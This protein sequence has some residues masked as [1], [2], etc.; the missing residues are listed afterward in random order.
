MVHAGRQIVG[1]RATPERPARTDFN[2]VR[3]HSALDNQTPNEFARHRAATL[4]P[5]QLAS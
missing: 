2:E 5:Q 1:G 4:N 3:P